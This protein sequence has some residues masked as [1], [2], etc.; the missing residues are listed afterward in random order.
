M[1]L[2]AGALLLAI[3]SVAPPEQG[4]AHAILKA[5]RQALGGEAALDAV[6]SFSLE[7]TGSVSLQGRSFPMSNKY[8]F[9][10]P[11]RYLRVQQEDSRY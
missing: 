3:L 1:R 2:A 9:V 5:M 11:D 8:Y 10:L 6:K 7:T 4:D